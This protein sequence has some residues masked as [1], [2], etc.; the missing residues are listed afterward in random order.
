MTRAVVGRRSVWTTM[1]R[2]ANDTYTMFALHAATSGYFLGHHLPTVR[3]RVFCYI[4]TCL[5]APCPMHGCLQPSCL[6]G[7]RLLAGFGD[8]SMSCCNSMCGN[9]LSTLPALAPSL[10]LFCPTSTASPL[11]RAGRIF[12]SS[13]RHIPRTLAG[14]TAS[15]HLRRGF[16]HTFQ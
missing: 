8:D 10:P 15:L 1:G 2:V 6:R 11:Q 16:A 3:V 9:T 5:F 7:G 12:P 14:D 4:R 13:L